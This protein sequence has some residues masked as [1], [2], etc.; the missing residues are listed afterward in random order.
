M[1]AARRQA[2]AQSTIRSRCRLWLRSSVRTA[3]LVVGLRGCALLFAPGLLADSSVRRGTRSTRSLTSRASLVTDSN[4]PEGHQGLHSALYGADEESAEAAH[5]APAEADLETL[6]PGRLDGSE[7][8]DVSHWLKGAADVSAE[9]FARPCVGLFALYTSDEASAV[10]A[11]VISS[12]NVPGALAAQLDGDASSGSHELRFAR[13]RLLGK[14]QRMWT[15]GRLEDERQ[16]WARELGAS[17]DVV[18]QPMHFDAR[19]P[20]SSATA[21]DAP[22]VGKAQQRAHE[23]LKWKM[24]MAMGTNLADAVEGEGDDGAARRLQFMKAVEGDDWSAVID[25]QTLDTIDSSSYSFD[26]HPIASPFAIGASRGRNSNAAQVPRE[27]N[28]K[29][30]K[31]ILEALRPVLV[32]DGG[33]VEVMGVDA[34]KGVVLLG[35]LGACQTCPSA[36]ATMESGLEKALFEHFGRDVLRE[37]V[38]VDAGAEATSAAGVRRQLEAH[39]DSLKDA[40]LKEGGYVRVVDD[41]AGGDG[42]DVHVSGPPMLCELV[43]SSVTYAFPE[44]HGRVNVLAVDEVAA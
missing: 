6:L 25:G 38:R 28:V 11:K 5:A 23:E 43:R 8:L 16:A 17:Q 36:P 2:A 29:N 15:R 22:S 30:V 42:C 19:S 41:E 7:V 14:M 34:E 12:R 20:D 1:M 40:L 24:Q 10:P 44:F 39:L 18:A 9:V 21:S 4:V 37:V 13:V 32:A 33:D 31:A 35:L 3:A 26:G 27:L